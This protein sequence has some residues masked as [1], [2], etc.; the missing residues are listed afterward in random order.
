MDTLNYQS[1]NRSGYDGFILKDA[2]EKVLQFGEGNFLRAFTDHFIDVMNETAGFNGK[3]VVVKPRSGGRVGNVINEQEGLYTLLLRGV[4]DGRKQEIKRVIS[5]ISRCIN[6]YTDHKGFLECAH[7]PEL[8][9]IVSNT[10]E[11]GITFDPG[12]SLTD[13]PPAGFPAKLTRFLY[14]RYNSGLPGFIILPCELIDRNGDVLRECVEEY[15]SLWKL[16]ADFSAWVRDENIFCSTLVDR[17]VPGYPKAEAG[18]LCESFGYSDGLLDSA[19]VFGSWVIEGPGFVSDEFPADRASLPVTFV[20]NVDP[21]KKRKVRI[22]N[23]A[24]TS[25]ALGA[26]LA[27]KDI[28]RD[29]MEDDVISGYLMAAVNDEIIPVLSDLDEKEVKD[30]AAAVRDRFL[31]PFMDHELLS[32]ALNSTAKWKARVMPTLI[33]YHAAKGTLPKMLTFSFAAYLSFYHSGYEMEDGA[34]KGLRGSDTFLIKDDE[35]VLEEFLSLKDADD[36]TLAEAIIGN[37]KMW[38][39]AL[40]DIAGFKEAVTGYLKLIADKGMYE[41]MRLI[42]QE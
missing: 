36:D 25:M 7:N 1:L 34:L 2:P 30:F 42:R 10:T 37:E 28:V 19:E 31:N 14:E 21:Y 22:L 38:G 15:I 5:C 11:A 35:Y 3:V 17:I 23:G 9:F 29:C 40:K 8:R 33:E 20:S 16:P 32:I 27:G 6:P 41:A 18:A 39:S 13:E 4:N 26:Y 12:C 24:H